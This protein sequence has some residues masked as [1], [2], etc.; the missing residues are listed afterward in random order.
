MARLATTSVAAHLQ[1]YYISPFGN[2]THVAGQPCLRL[3][4]LAHSQNFGYVS[5]TPP[6]QIRNSTVVD[7]IVTKCGLKGS[8]TEILRNADFCWAKSLKTFMFPNMIFHRKKIILIIIRL[9]GCTLQ[10][11]RDRLD[12]SLTEQKHKL[13]QRTDHGRNSCHQNQKF[14]PCKKKKSQNL[15]MILNHTSKRFGYKS[16]RL[17][18]WEVFELKSILK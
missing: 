4:V 9:H 11:G 12:V 5:S 2:A 10:W 18:L 7:L 1:K 6:Q 13:T 3:I 14:W 17:L 16:R 15:L 8:N